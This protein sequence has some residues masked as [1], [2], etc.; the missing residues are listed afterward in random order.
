MN[1]QNKTTYFQEFIKGYNSEA[2]NNPSIF[3]SPQILNSTLKDINMG[4]EKISKKRLERMVMSPH[5]FEQDLRKISY[6]LYKTVSLYQ[7]VIKLWSNMLEFDSEPIPYVKDGGE[8]CLTDMTSEEFKKDYAVMKKFFD[9][10]KVKQEFLKVLWNI[11]LYD[12]Y[13]TSFRT[14]KDDNDEEH[15]YLQELP[16][17]H[18][19]IDAESYLGY[20]FSFDLSY[21]TNMG[22]DINAYSPKIREL[23]AEIIKSGKTTNYNTNLPNRNGKWVYWTP[24]NPNDA[25][26]FKYN[27]Q[28]AGSVP[29]LLSMLLDYCEID[30]FKDLNKQKQAL[31][32]Y[33]VICATVPMLKNN[34]TGNKTDDFAISAPELGQFIATVKSTL[35][36]GVDFKAAPLEDFKAFDFS[37]S[38]N[39]K[40]I[41]DNALKNIM[42]QSGL[43][44]ALSMTNTVNVASANIYKQFHGKAMSNLYPQF[45]RFCEYHINKNTKK[46]NFKINFVGTMFD[47]DERIKRANDDMERG[48]ITPSIF[49]SRGIQV[50]DGVNA[51]NFMYAMGVPEI[52]KPIKT[53]STMSSI[54][55]EG[56]RPLK[57]ESELGDS[58][59][60]TRTSGSNQT[61]KEVEVKN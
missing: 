19:I 46:Y 44:D 14:Y 15:Y 9:G 21:F 10:F 3:M 36:N 16:S 6:H 33:K 49:S 52:F 39:S 23:Y 59:A 22:V 58:G 12:T 27:T 24:L 40:D 35:Q 54:K 56:G 7:Q 13:Y 50:T 43:T 31:E 51:M 29:P 1:K 48:I 26:V 18:C 32:V 4:S 8:I 37:S 45:S 11:C 17:S 55:K 53:A 41:L 34:R 5:F 42:K 38:S 25:W 57:E 28:F 61:T 60:N 20:L 47:K 30:E 2:Y